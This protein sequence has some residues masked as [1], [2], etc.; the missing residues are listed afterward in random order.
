MSA[1]SQLAP[2][3]IILYLYLLSDLCVAAAHPGEVVRHRPTQCRARRH[4][5]EKHR[6][7]LLPQTQVVR[8]AA[9]DLGIQRHVECAAIWAIGMIV[10]GQMTAA[11]FAQL[12]G[13]SSPQHNGRAAQ[14]LEVTVR[15]PDVSR[16]SK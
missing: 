12:R 13:A 9:L 15:N 1:V 5:L 3:Y 2:T 16:V 10:R 8:N 11:I 6:T 4:R 14:I 7:L